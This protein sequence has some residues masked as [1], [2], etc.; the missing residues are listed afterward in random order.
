MGLLDLLAE[1]GVVSSRGEARRA[2]E[3]G[4][5]YL[6]NERATDPRAMVALEHAVEGAFLV[7]RK[8]KRNYHLVRVV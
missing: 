3:G 2:V 6:N 5:I 1:A 8:G 7:I 4:G